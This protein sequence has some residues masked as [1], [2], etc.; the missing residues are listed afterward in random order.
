MHLL[1]IE[2][3]PLPSPRADLSQGEKVNWKCKHSIYVSA[4]FVVVC[5]IT[6]QCILTYLPVIARNFRWVLFSLRREPQN[7]KSH[8][9]LVSRLL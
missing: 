5:I 3:R 7:E 8:E 2:Q 4:S 6:V 1:R 9:N